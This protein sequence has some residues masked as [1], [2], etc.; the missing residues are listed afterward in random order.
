LVS[1]G[2]TSHE[3]LVALGANYAPLLIQEGQ[4]WRLLT[5]MFLHIGAL[6]LFLNGYA[7]YQLGNL[8]ERWTGSARFTGVYFATGLAGS[9]ASTL[10]HGLL[11]QP[12]ISAGASGAIFGLLG[13]VIALL[14]RRRD[15][16]TD[17]A[18]ALLRQL[19]F[20]AGLN[21]LLAF[22]GMPL[23]NAAHLGGFACGLALGFVIR[24]SWERAVAA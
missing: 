23:D 15:R 24:P 7:L 12:V 14:A 11:G 5:S 4:W 17:S 8:Y 13:A 1:G 19:A 10:F 20:W 22:T 3:T 9:L 21:I 18:R 6:H 2:S 16:L